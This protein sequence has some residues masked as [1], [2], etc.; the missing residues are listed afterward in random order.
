MFNDSQLPKSEVNYNFVNYKIGSIF[1]TFNL[2]N[3][4][5]NLGPHCSL[6]SNKCQSSLEEPSSRKCLSEDGA[7]VV[8]RMSGDASEKSDITSESI[9]PNA[10]NTSGEFWFSIYYN[11]IHSFEMGIVYD[12]DSLKQ[13]STDISGDFS[14]FINERRLFI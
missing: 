5:D 3:C 9:P 8:Q 13:N 12:S 2:G 7:A 11:H 6:A 14:H 4:R 10:T 1:Y